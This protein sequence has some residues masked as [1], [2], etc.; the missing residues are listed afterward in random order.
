VQRMANK[1]VQW[2][3]RI[4]LWR[5]EVVKTSNSLEINRATLTGGVAQKH[6]CSVELV[7][8]EDTD[9]R[10]TESYGLL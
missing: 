1:G 2:Y 7:E 5:M 3:G 8:R 6:V 9:R 4:G 10:M